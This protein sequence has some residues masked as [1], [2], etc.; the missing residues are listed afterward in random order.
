M[1]KS[2]SRFI[3]RTF[4]RPAGRMNLVSKQL[5]V[6]HLLA[7]ASPATVCMLLVS[8]FLLPYPPD[9]ALTKHGYDFVIRCLGFKVGHKAGQIE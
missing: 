2:T 6:I 1:G 4:T 7:Y 9:N 3:S 5:L 8:L